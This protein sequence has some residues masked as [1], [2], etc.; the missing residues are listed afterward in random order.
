MVATCALMMHYP[1]SKIFE[2]SGETEQLF[3]LLLKRR[4]ITY[5]RKCCMYVD[6]SEPEVHFREM[7]GE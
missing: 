6:V 2:V 5:A 1:M 4:H 7:Q 3:P